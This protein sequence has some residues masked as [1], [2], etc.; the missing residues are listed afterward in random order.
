MHDAGTVVDMMEQSAPASDA[1]II[2]LVLGGDAD[3]F[4]TIVERHEERV[5]GVVARHVPREEVEAVAH[6]VFV[7]AYLSLATYEGRGGFAGWLSRIALRA[8]SDF[9]RERYRRRERVESSLSEEE[10]RWM[11][12]A[13]SDRSAAFLEE[14]ESARHASTLLD[15]ALGR[16]SPAA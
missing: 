3:A 15:R 10:R 1:E 12:R 4:E 9:W 2:E 7:R 6:D 14:R 13:A 11:D 16:L 5:V 8:C